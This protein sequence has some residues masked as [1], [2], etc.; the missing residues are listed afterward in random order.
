[1]SACFNICPPASSVILGPWALKV[2]PRWQK[3][4]TKGGPLMITEG[5]WFQHCLLWKCE[6]TLL[7]TLQ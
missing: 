3:Q 5:S 6:E 4:V 1:M 7:H 2:E